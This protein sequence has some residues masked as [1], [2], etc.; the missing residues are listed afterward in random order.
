MDRN[1]IYG[2]VRVCY[3]SGHIT[4]LH[5]RDKQAI[6]AWRIWLHSMIIAYAIL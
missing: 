5:K 3:E 4:C 1:T 6:M 2:Y